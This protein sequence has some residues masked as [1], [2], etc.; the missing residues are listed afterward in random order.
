MSADPV[1]L[2]LTAIGTLVSGVMS[3]AG[4][5]QQA[6]QA[7]YAAAQAR[8]DAALQRQAADAEVVDLQRSH[9]RQMGTIRA[10][11]A[12]SGLLVDDSG[13]LEA[14]LVSAGEAELEVL[15][16]KW[17]GDVGAQRGESEATMYE[18]RAREARSSGLF[19]AGA[20]LLTG[21]SRVYNLLGGG[22][23]AGL[24]LGIGDGRKPGSIG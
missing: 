22:G 24:G 11:A 14:A 12:A 10:N 15:R 21:G 5:N 17:Q 2:A 13:A 20:Q 23:G 1:S 6:A 7:D 4:G 19:R 9:R 3:I 8:Q 18:A 16:R